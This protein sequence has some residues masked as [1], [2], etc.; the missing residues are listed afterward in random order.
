MQNMASYQARR[1][2]LVRMPA[3]LG[4]GCSGEMNVSTAAAGGE[5]GPHLVVSESRV[6]FS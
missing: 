6:L 1:V 4:L 2:S 5:G 3:L